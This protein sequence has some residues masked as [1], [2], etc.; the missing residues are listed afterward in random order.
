MND[1]SHLIT[2][3]AGAEGGEEQS[4]PAKTLPIFQEGCAFLKILCTFPVII[5]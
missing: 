3:L 1:L 2:D 4:L 5:A